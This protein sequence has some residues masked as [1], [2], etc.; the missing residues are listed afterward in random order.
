MCLKFGG[1]EMEDKQLICDLLLKALQATRKFA[2]LKSLTYRNI[3]PDEE[4]VEACFSNGGV[5]IAN[6][7]MDS[8]I[9]M[10]EDIIRQV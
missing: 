2:D 7:S 6:V 4:I 1:I 5:R 8:G 10:I 3:S 9:A